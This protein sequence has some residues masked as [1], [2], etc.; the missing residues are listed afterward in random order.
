MQA[1]EILFLKQVFLHITSAIAIAP[2]AVNVLSFKFKICQTKQRH[3]HM[4]LK[5]YFLHLS[6]MFHG[7]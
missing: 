4:I 1:T 5:E 7:A 2:F 6:Y 3:I